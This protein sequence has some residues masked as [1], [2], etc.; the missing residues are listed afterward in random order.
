MAILSLCL[1]NVVAATD[2]SPPSGMDK[3]V[4]VLKDVKPDFETQEGTDAYYNNEVDVSEYSVKGSL[5]WRDPDCSGTEWGTSSWEALPAVLEPAVGQNTTLTAEVG[6]SQSCSGRHVNAYTKLAVG[7]RDLSP[8][9]DVS[10][11]SSDPKPAPVS[12][13]VPW[14]APW[15]KMGD[16]LTVTIVANVPGAV[17]LHHYLNYVYAYEASGSQP[18]QLNVPKQSESSVQTNP[19]Q[20]HELPAPAPTYVSEGTQPLPKGSDDDYSSGDGEDKDTNKVDYDCYGGLNVDSG[21]R[22]SD[23]SGQVDIRPGN[24]ENAWKTAEIKTIPCVCDHVRTGEDSCAIISFADMTTFVM[25]PETEIILDTPP[26]KDARTKLVSGRIWEN[27]KK[28]IREGSME[29]EMSQAVAGIKGTTIVCEETGS[30]S[31]LKVL[32]GTARFTSKATGEDILV[33]AGEMVTATESS[34]SAPQSFDV[35]AENA[36]WEELAPKPEDTGKETGTNEVIFN[37]WNLGSVDNSPSC[38]PSFTITEPYMITY[39][40]TY[41][42]NYGKG[43]EAGGIITIRCNDDMMEYT[44]PVETKSGQ[45]GVPNAWWIAHPNWAIPAGTYEIVDSDADTWSQN[46]ESGGCGFSKVEGYPV[47]EK[48]LYGEQTDIGPASLEETSADE[49]GQTADYWVKMGQAHIESSSY[50][51]ALDNFE[52]ALQADPQSADAWF[53]KG[54]ALV[55]LNNNEDAEESFD[56]AINIDPTMAQSWWGKG[57]VAAS[58]GRYEEAIELFDKAI[59]LDPQ[60]ARYWNS[61]GSALDKLERYEEAVETY[62]MAIMLDSQNAEYLFNKANSLCF[63]GKA[64][65]AI[66]AIDKAIELDPQNALYWYLKGNALEFLEKWEEALNAYDQAA[67]LDPSEAL[68]WSHEGTA[69]EAL[70]RTSEAEIAL[71]K[72]MGLG[73]TG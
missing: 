8:I 51:E 57:W 63:L 2:Q 48:V 44:W 22:F 26:T 20:E 9:A 25:K 23:L 60:Q 47:D 53:G 30:S 19:Q 42:W 40:D 33:S 5:S 61:K 66:T 73:Y 35:D 69:L 10:F 56:N 34:I 70:G 37:N 16:T 12:V 1:L 59:Q 17:A 21:A 64:D 31:T 29:V 58:K 39:V 38:N 4:W 55:M 65:I 41:H 50:N 52:K 24:K 13:K 18:E 7:D 46:S 62:E 54:W 45:G 32:E 11:D 43:T 68:Y 27:V 72:A 15:G 28:M 3:G 14:E 71:A 67:E 49:E 6:G 36:S